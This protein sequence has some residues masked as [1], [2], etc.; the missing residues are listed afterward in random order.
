MR[1]MRGDSVTTYLVLAIAVLMVGG[2]A[3]AGLHR[4]MTWLQEL[5]GGRAKHELVKLMQEQA[6]T[7]DQ[8]H[9]EEIRRHVN[10]PLP[11]WRVERRFRRHPNGVSRSVMCFHPDTRNAH[12]AFSAAS[13]WHRTTS[14]GRSFTIVRAFLSR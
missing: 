9:K 8:A 5:R 2:I 10:R 14:T 4:L 11:A 7:Q 6:A 1:L 3:F 12:S 13:R